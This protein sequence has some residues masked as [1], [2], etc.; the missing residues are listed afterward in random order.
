[1]FVVAVTVYATGVPTAPEDELSVSHGS[2]T[3]AVHVPLPDVMMA[4]P[5]PPT[6]KFRVVGV[7]EILLFFAIGGLGSGAD[8]KDNFV[9]VNV[10]V[11]S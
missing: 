1:M 2:E 11:H 7:I 4:L 3:A 9:T 5:P 10:F 6:E 8:V